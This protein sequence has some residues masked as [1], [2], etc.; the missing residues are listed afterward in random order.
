MDNPADPQLEQLL[1][2]GQDRPLLRLWI[3]RSQA[4][5]ARPES[6]LCEEWCLGKLARDT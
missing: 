1:S 4:L 3:E 6:F 2:K 5:M